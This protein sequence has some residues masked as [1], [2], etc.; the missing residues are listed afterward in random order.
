MIGGATFRLRRMTDE[1]R[2]ALDDAHPIQAAR[3]AAYLQAVVVG[4]EGVED[5]AGLPLPYDAGLV[6]YLDWETIINPLL[7]RLRGGLDPL[8]A[9]AASATLPP[10]TGTLNG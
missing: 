6:K 4:W 8:A 3:T 1:E 5:E 10:S 7:E 2:A 9:R